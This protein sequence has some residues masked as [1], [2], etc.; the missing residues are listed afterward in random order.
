MANHSNHCGVAVVEKGR[1]VTNPQAMRLAR[2]TKIINK[3]VTHWAYRVGCF[4]R[5]T[6]ICKPWHNAKSKI[7]LSNIETILDKSDHVSDVE[8]SIKDAVFAKSRGI[9]LRLP[10]KITVRVTPTIL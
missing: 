10:H 1:A 5:Q 9:T 4:I 8:K 6:T 2:G 3:I 7:L